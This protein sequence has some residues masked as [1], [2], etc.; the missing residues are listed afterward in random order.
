MW[1][2]TGWAIVTWLKITLLLAVGVGVAWLALPAGSGWFWV[3]LLGAG[4]A[5]LFTT[6]QLTREWVDR[7]RWSWW[8]A[9]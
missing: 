2:V 3:A 5:E 1:D 6:R 8:W 9:R 4:A 7:A